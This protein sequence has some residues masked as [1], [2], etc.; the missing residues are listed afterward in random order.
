MK[1]YVA[2]IEK[3]SLEDAN[4]RT[5]LYTAKHSQLVLMTLRAGEDIGEE[6][7]GVDQFFRI[8]TGDGKAVLDGVEHEL[9]DGFVVVVP[10]GCKHNI[11]N[12][13][14]HNPL[15]LYTLY[16]PPNHKNGTAHATKAIAEADEGEHWSGETSE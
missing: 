4:F 14:P 3:L 7:H 13:S 10:A 16:S 1:G 12:T 9:H 11:I 2:N 6:V 5:V 8:E 15:K